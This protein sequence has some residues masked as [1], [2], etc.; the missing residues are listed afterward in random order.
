MLRDFHSFPGRLGTAAVAF[1]FLMA[2]AAYAIGR[3]RQRVLTR[4]P[5]P[6]Q[7]TPRLEVQLL[8]FSV[9][10]LV[11]VSLFTVTR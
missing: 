10:V 1:A 7:L 6:T 8:G 2:F 3:R 5:L 4:R 9:L 11:V